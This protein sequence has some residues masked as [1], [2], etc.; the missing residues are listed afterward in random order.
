M[1]RKEPTKKRRRSSTS[2]TAPVWTHRHTHQTSLHRQFFHTTDG[3][4]RPT[5][6]SLFEQVTHGKCNISVGRAD[7]DVISS[8]DNSFYCSNCKSIF[9]PNLAPII[10][11][12]F[13]RVAKAN[14]WNTELQKMQNLALAL[15]G[16]TIE[17]LREK[18]ESTRLGRTRKF[19]TFWLT[20]LAIWMSQRE[21][22]GSLIIARR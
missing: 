13:E 2:R 7:T 8:C 21:P 10:S 20:V 6:C 16:P 11:E 5:Q 22:C 9:R 1:W 18:C 15:E 3:P 4:S 12:H 19:G 17:C 14:G